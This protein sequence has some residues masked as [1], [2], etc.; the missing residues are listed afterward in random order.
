MLAWLLGC[1]DCVANTMH[2]FT[3]GAE[4]TRRPPQLP[5]LLARYRVRPP[6]L[7]AG[8]DYRVGVPPELALK[9]PATISVPGVSVDPAHYL[10]RI[11]RDGITLRGYDFGLGRGWGIYIPSGASD[12]VIED[13]SFRL[14]PTNNV[15]INATNSG[16]LTVRHC[17]FEGN[18]TKDGTA[19]AMISFSGKGNVV[20]EHNA[21]QNVP[22][23]GIDFNQGEIVPVIRYNLF[24]NIGSAP[25][26]HADSIQFDGTHA[27][28]TV[29]AFN[30]VD[31]GEEGIQLDAQNGS[32]LTHSVITNNV[33][34]AQGPGKTISY[35]IAAGES[36]G[37]RA[38]GIVIGRN[39]LDYTGAYGPFY[40]PVGSRMSYVDNI[41]MVTGAPVP[42]PPGT[43]PSDVI[44]VETSAPVGIQRGGL[45]ISITIELDTPAFVTGQP[46]LELNNGAKA[47]YAGGSGTTRLGF[48][49]TAFVQDRGIVALASRGVALRGGA[50]IE[51]AN[52]NALNLD[53]AIARLPLLQDRRSSRRPGH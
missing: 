45:T 3:D 37:S 13:S 4:P 42:S 39:Y 51:D 18:A 47:G 44:S 40:R 22:E 32:V 33:V 20:I 53:G 25:G 29:I 9:D 10:V 38:E 19:W 16:N 15:P 48:A 8:V 49:Y 50:R 52:G 12:T 11:L 21:F 46:V 35:L 24:T 30:T 14:G 17:T 5:S 27:T 31:S 1:R 43:S 41:D 7:V 6:W 26:A 23:D 36:S 28:D 2:S 34:V